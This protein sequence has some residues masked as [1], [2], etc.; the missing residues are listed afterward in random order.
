M[1]EL[2]VI[3]DANILVSAYSTAGRIQERLQAGL[4][5]HELF[6]SPEIFAEVERTLRQAEFQL[7]PVKIRTCLKEILSRCRLV[8][9]KA[10]FTGDI[11]D[12]KDRHLV[13]LALEVKA[14]TI[15]MGEL[16]L[17]EEKAIAG[18]TVQKLS[19]LA[20]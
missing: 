7:S 4:G 13:N 5:P 16:G 2:R 15:I 3:I 17:R 20:A 1:K 9:P 10:K 18:I 6:I 14:D 8:R 12:E 11:S 19:E